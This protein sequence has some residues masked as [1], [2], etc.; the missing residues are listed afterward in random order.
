MIAFFRIA[1]L[2]K[3]LRIVHEPIRHGTVE[4]AC[5]SRR[6]KWR[7]ILPSPVKPDNVDPK[8]AHETLLQII[9]E[10]KAREA[11]RKKRVAKAA[12]ASRKR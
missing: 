12:A 11:G 10:R 2:F 3:E 9:A 5:Y 1:L 6:V 7:Q 4:A 8:L